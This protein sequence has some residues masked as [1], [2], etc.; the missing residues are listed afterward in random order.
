MDQMHCVVIMAGG[1]GQRF[2]PMSREAYPKQFLTLYGNRS[3]LQYSYQRARR[4]VRP[5]NIYISTRL[6]LECAIRK[7]I[8]RLSKD[9]LIV[10]PAGRDTAPS[11][12]LSCIWVMRRAPE[13][14]MM[15]MPADHY[16][17]PTD[18]FAETATKALLLAEKSND[19][20]II[21]IT[22]TSPSTGY[23]YIQCNLTSQRKR[24]LSYPVLSFK[25]KP[26]LATAER[27]LREGN[28]FWNSGIFVAKT[29]T[30][31]EQIQNHAPRISNLA[32][33]LLGLSEPIFHARL[34]RI[35]RR[36]PKVS[37]DYA[38]MEKSKNVAMIPAEFRWNDLGSWSSLDELPHLRKERNVSLGPFL[39]LGSDGNIISTGQ[40]LAVLVDVKDLVVALTDDALLVCHKNSAQKIKQVVT[41]L[42]RTKHASCT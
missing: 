25:E 37:L 8:P 16:V 30:M 12:M 17:T 22:P 35:F 28:Y 13:A 5:E 32:R 14:T 11:I 20:V 7:Q 29:S 38:V 18:R 24:L 15:F 26:N 4:I 31:V 6:G 42:K 23:G 41:S 36:M 3:L 34:S 2:W 27:Y 40:K 21:G 39:A 1:S 9:N 10:E 33:P 19:I